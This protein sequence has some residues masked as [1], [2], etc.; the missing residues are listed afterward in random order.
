MEMAKFLHADATGWE[1]QG[2]Q[3]RPES[4]NSKLPLEI[5]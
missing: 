5:K 2:N 3:D 4:N 1:I